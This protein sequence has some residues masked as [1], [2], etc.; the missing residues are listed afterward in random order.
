MSSDEDSYS[1]I[2]TSL[3]HPIRRK[4]LRILSN[5]PQTFSD[6]LKQFKIESSHLT[7]H[8]DGLGNLLNKNEEG[9]YTLSS[10]GEAAVS[11]MKNVEEPPSTSRPT[12]KTDGKKPIMKP[13]TLIF[14]CG[15]IA[16]LIL[17]SFLLLEYI[18][19]SATNSETSKIN[20]AETV[21]LE[22]LNWQF[23]RFDV[24]K[25]WQFDFNG[26][27]NGS[28]FDAGTISENVFIDFNFQASLYFRMNITADLNQGFVESIKVITFD[29]LSSSHFS[30][31]ID[32]DTRYTILLENLT[33]STAGSNSLILAN[34]VNHPRR[35]S[36][37]L[38]PS[39]SLS[40]P[41][42]QNESV[43]LFAVV[44]YF[45]GTSYKKAVRPF[46]LTLI[47]YN[48][49]SF[50]SAEELQINGTA[51]ERVGGVNRTEDFYKIHLGTGE[52]ANV[53]WTPV[54]GSGSLYIYSS[55]N[56]SSPLYISPLPPEFGYG[57]QSITFTANHSGWWYIK[58]LTYFA[59]Y[60]LDCV[61]LS[62]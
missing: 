51:I 55:E 46:N 22:P 54:V 40:S 44:T 45:N 35:V 13:L 58:V 61:T 34:G 8:I 21:F 20:S 7:Y 12:L 62:P 33:D 53:T 18:Q 30:F 43:T 38:S 49:T 17:S 2:F 39:L 50:E 48:N 60:Y 16:L 29:S 56:L 36:M 19:L 23:E 4:I 27:V 24:A 15:L 52:T 41:D 9:K 26:A 3:K 6:L 47:A 59:M 31:G 28:Y 57:V 42:N 37:L 25:E 32:G 5:E 11:M 1:V 14:T 10:L